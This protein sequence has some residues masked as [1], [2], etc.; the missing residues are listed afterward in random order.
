MSD[1]KTNKHAGRSVGLS[2]LGNGLAG[3]AGTVA[4]IYAINTPSPVIGFVRL[5]I[6]AITLLI[7]A[8]FLGGK[9]SQLPRLI[10]RPGVWIMGASSASYQVFFF[11]SVDR[12]GVATAALITVG[13]IP[14]SA[15]IVGWI[16]LR[17]R[18]SRIWYVSTAIAISGLVVA[19]LGELQ[20]NDA[21][22]LIFA[23]I[24]GSGI[25]AYINAAKIEVRAGG[26]SSQLPGMAFLLGSIGLFFVVRSDLLQMEWTT[27]TILLAVYLGAVTMGIANGIQMLGLRGISPGVASTMMLA[28]PVTAAVLGVVVLGE[29][30]TLNGT[31]GLILVVIGLAMQS[32]SA[33]EETPRSKKVGRHRSS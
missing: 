24:A 16:F 26:H 31:V 33:G 21:T 27:Q 13:C 5:F 1:S 28:D 23:V 32:F 20:T 11:A 3:T 4:A 25:G 9:L 19:S 17:E 2:L 12:T 7:L 8:P 22:G 18:P 30:V 6:G 10:T 29:A 15:G 14:V